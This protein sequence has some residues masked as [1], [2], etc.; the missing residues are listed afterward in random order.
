MC[1]AGADHTSGTPQYAKVNLRRNP[2]DLNTARLVDMRL[3][4]GRHQFLSRGQHGDLL[5]KWHMDRHTLEY[6]E[7]A[8]PAFAA[9]YR[10]S[11]PGFCASLREAFPVT[12]SRILDVGAGSGRDVSTLL[13]LGYIAFRTEPCAAMRREAE[14]HFPELAG[15][16]FAEG[17]PFKDQAALGGPYDGILCSAVLMHVP[18]NEIFNALFSLKTPE[19]RR[20]PVH[21]RIGR[22]KRH[23]R[24][25]PSSRHRPPVQCTASRTVDLTAKR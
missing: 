3:S 9:R 2:A 13:Q 21:L 17:L 7:T 15:R 19:G 14:S 8:A 12:R 25:S 20:P 5:L 4:A 16:L 24:R 23:R 6:Y 22:E 11:D 18:E 10:A 1:R